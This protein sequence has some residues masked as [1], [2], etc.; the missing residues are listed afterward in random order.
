M[1]PPHLPP[2]TENPETKKF[3][4][5]LKWFLFILVISLIA[6]MSGASMMLGWVWPKFTED[7]AWITSYTRAGL[8]RAQLENLIREEISSRILTVYRGS[9]S[10]GGVSYFSK[11]IGD[12][13]MLSSDG[14]LATYQPAY[15]GV[16]KNI[17]VVSSDGNVYV[18]EDAVWDKY[19][20]VLYIK[21]TSDQFKVVEFVEENMP[22]DDV[23]IWQDADWY[24][25]TILYPVLNYKI[26]HLDAAPV[27]SYSVSSV[28]SPGSIAIN[29]QG[30]V[31]G[32]ISE[33][34]V[35]LPIS[36]LT[37]VLSAV[38]SKQT[39]SYPS[40]GVE[41]WFSEE[42]EVFVESKNKT[43]VKEKTNGFL[44]TNILSSGNSLRKGD[45]ITEINGRIVSVDNLWYII[46]AAQTVQTKVLRAGKI[47]EIDVQVV[48]IK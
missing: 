26:P 36:R 23:F 2:K 28:F 40:L 12:G 22:L 48:Q 20:G 29:N 17:S 18:A 14:W 45:L 43:G 30:R 37:H 4:H 47:M 41:G 33:S 31:A 1:T 34:G 35:L 16:H 11:K 7:D 15:D 3:L 19:A 24:H 5:R 13:I 32:F 21:I 9:T 27:R 25:G 8:S 46:S 6:G 38:L 44:V 39:I 42:Q 10:L